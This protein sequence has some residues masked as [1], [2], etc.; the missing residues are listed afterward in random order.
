M[1]DFGTVYVAEARDGPLVEKGRLHRGPSIPQVLRKKTGGQVVRSRL[2]SEFGKEPI[3]VLFGCLEEVHEAE[4]SG[5]REH[6]GPAVFEINDDPIM[7]PII[8]LGIRPQQSPAACHTKMTH[9][10]QI[11]GEPD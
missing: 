1:E 10:C 5:I 8:T 3:L 4:A 7:F 11:A 9:P 2:R 6:R